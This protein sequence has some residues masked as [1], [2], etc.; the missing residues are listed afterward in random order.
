MKA[1][2]I[3]SWHVSRPES[4]SG[5]DANENYVHITGRLPGLVQ[6]LLGLAGITSTSEL[7][8][9]AHRIS[10]LESSLGGQIQYHTP[11]ENVCATLYGYKKPWK[12]AQILGLIAGC[13]FYI[14][15]SRVGQTRGGVV[16]LLGALAGIGIA[17][18][19]YVLT[20]TITIGFTDMGGRLSYFHFKPSVIE[21]K[22]ISNE[23]AAEVCQVIQTL[24]ERYNK[25]HA[26]ALPTSASTDSSPVNSGE[27][28]RKKYYYADADSQ[29]QGPL[30]FNEL[31]ALE[32]DGI[33]TPETK[34]I[35][36][37]ATQWSTWAASKSNRK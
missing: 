30:S 36:E 15:L 14:F 37:G 22:S 12:E 35:I 9:N 25:S 32:K 2:V 3:K 19:V 20:K 18:L 11:L 21:G 1:F 33:I 17:L 23:S 7:M 4:C 6:Y 27:A 28:N 34:V 5:A 10:Y 24:V 13:A 8:I 31:V 26:A 29:S 16:F